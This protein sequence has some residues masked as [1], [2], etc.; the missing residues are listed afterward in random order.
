MNYIFSG[1][2]LKLG[3]LNVGDRI[4]RHGQVYRCTSI[5]PYVT[6]AGEQSA[7]ADWQSECATCGQA[8]AVQTG[9]KNFYPQNTRCQK[10]KNP[11]VPSSSK[12]LA[13]KKSMVRA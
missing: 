6:K 10:H 3:N 12:A 4:E 11:R 2:V 7:I 8:F 5:K 13:A 1:P 9:V